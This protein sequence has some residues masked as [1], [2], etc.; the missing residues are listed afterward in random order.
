MS[1]KPK[2]SKETGD[3]GTKRNWGSKDDVDVDGD[4]FRIAL[5]E[6]EIECNGKSPSIGWLFDLHSENWKKKPVPPNVELPAD[7]TDMTMVE[8]TLYSTKVSSTQTDQAFARKWNKRIKDDVAA[9]IVVFQKMFE[10]TA[11]VSDIIAT[12][13]GKYSSPKG[14]WCS[15]LVVLQENF[16]PRSAADA[17]DYKAQIKALKD[18]GMKFSDYYI[19]L[20]RLTDILVDMDQMIP[21]L[22]MEAIVM[23]NVTNPDFKPLMVQLTLQSGQTGK[24]SYDYKKFLSECA[25]L[26]A[27]RKVVNNWGVSKE[28]EGSPKKALAATKSESGGRGVVTSD[29]LCWQCGGK[30]FQSDCVAKVCGK[31]KASLRNKDGEKVTHDATCCTGGKSK[32]PVRVASA[33]GGGGKGSKGKP[34]SSPKK[35]GWEEKKQKKSTFLPSPESIPPNKKRAY[36]LAI[37]DSLKGEADSEEE[38]PKKKSKK[39]KIRSWDPAEESE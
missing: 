36:A 28:S 31:C 25:T 11:A 2:K 22:E 18:A 38:V 24:R 30:H 19:Q 35:G 39:A 7:T 13:I 9:G 6:A 16:A 26:A 27:A 29:V 3:G 23:E 37:M 10:S 20:K 8:A 32:I 33:K 12:A 15:L 1:T 21:P 5:R 34:D 14:Q 4:S 17:M